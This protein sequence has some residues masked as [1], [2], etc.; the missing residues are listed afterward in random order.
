M[1]I[2]IIGFGR[3]GKRHARLLTSMGITT[4]ILDTNPVDYD[5]I[6]AI[7][8]DHR[9]RVYTNFETAVED[10]IWNIACI[11]TPPQFHLNYIEQCLQNSMWVTCEKP[12]S[13]FG[14]IYDIEAMLRSKLPLECVQI[15]YNY[16]YNSDMQEFDT[17]IKSYGWQLITSQ[18]RPDLPEW[19]TILD[20]LSHA[21]DI[22][23]WTSKKNFSILD[24]TQRLYPDKQEIVVNGKMDDGTPVYFFDQVCLSGKPYR[25]SRLISPFG[26]ME[27]TPNPQMFVKMYESFFENY[28]LG[29]P[30][31]PGV[32]DALETQ[33]ILQ[34][35]FEKTVVIENSN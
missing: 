30:Q 5:E 28:R 29:L 20:H 26:Y 12:L 18:Y 7:Y 13:D 16:R 17:S 34:K 22:V 10:N 9:P 6:D 25:V 32:K 31:Y 3:A 1:N 2:L 27:I 33:K 15:Q 21:V 35:I 14:R 24:C 8:G 4:G 11:A 19:G 23:R